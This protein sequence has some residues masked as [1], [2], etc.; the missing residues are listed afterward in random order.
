MIKK[1]FFFKQKF[2]FSHSIILEESEDFVVGENIKL[3]MITDKKNRYK[4]DPANST[5]APTVTR[6]AYQS[7]TAPVRGLYILDSDEDGEIVVFDSEEN[8]ETYFDDKL[9]LDLTK[10]NL[11]SLLEE[12]VKKFTVTK[13]TVNYFLKTYCL[14]T[15][16]PISYKFLSEEEK[17]LIY[18]R[19]VKGI[20]ILQEQ[21][22]TRVDS[23]KNF[24]QKISD[25]L[26]P[27]TVT[28][29]LLTEIVTE[30][31]EFFPKVDKPLKSYLDKTLTYIKSDDC[32]N[33]FFPDGFEKVHRGVEFV[34][35]H[36]ETK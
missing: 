11:I 23:E 32:S 9:D 10:E 34:F 5:F 13:S 36:L 24:L 26:F 6:K 14:K 27:E 29:E 16:Q 2:S 3:L 30:L 12:Q 31:E 15:H 17:I 22:V 20:F 28:D 1:E 8:P 7:G 4:R 25:N 19:V 21:F 35:N 33:R 18:K